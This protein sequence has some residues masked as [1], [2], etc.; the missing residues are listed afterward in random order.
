MHT[1][2]VLHRDIKS[3]NILFSLDGEIKITDLGFAC[4]LDEKRNQRKTKIGTPNWVAPEIVRGVMYDKS[5][6]IWSYGCFAYEL[7]TG[8]PP[9]SEI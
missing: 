4:S 6:D 9:F 3:D 1:N 2:N 7:A 5:V 8:M